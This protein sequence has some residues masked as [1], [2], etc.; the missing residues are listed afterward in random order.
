MKMIEQLALIGVISLIG[1]LSGFIGATYALNRFDFY[2]IIVDS[3]DSLLADKE[4]LAKVYALGQL[5]GR[6]ITEGAGLGKIKKKGGK[7]FGIPSE[8]VMPF[9]ERFL[10]KPTETATAEEKRNLYIPP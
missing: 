8:L 7:I 10:K 6:G 3:F 5:L 9:V 4:N 1:G 2:P